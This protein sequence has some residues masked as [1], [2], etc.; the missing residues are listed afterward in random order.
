MTSAGPS[1]STSERRLEWEQPTGTKLRLQWTASPSD[2]IAVRERSQL[3]RYGDPFP[4]IEAAWEAHSASQRID[5]LPLDRF[6]L[7]RLLG[8]LSYTINHMQSGTLQDQLFTL[9]DRLEAAERYGDGTL[10]TFRA[11]APRP[12]PRSKKLY[13]CRKDTFVSI[14]R[15][16]PND[17]IIGDAFVTVVADT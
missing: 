3:L 15:H 1:T 11:T 17:P 4:R 13:A 8:D 16:I 14:E 2:L 12:P 10:D 6:E 9:C 5:V 7:K